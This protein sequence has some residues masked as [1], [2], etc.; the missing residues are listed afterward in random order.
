M[1]KYR[2]V[3]GAI[4]N[5]IVIFLIVLLANKNKELEVV[6]ILAGII[7]LV[8][9]G[10]WVYLFIYSRE[11]RVIGDKMILKKQFRSS[12]TYSFDRISY[13]ISF[14]LKSSKYIALKMKIVPL[15]NI[16]S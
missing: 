15:K 3:F 13:P 6:M 14:R 8:L 9:I 5:L 4:L 7:F 12:K 2:I 1:D 11:A 16:L 10:F